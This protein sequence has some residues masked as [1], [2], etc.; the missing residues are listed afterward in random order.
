M[1][2]KPSKILLVLLSVA[3][4]QSAF[5]ATSANL[6]LRGTVGAANAISIASNGTN[7][8]TLDVL[9]GEINKNVASATEVSN[10]AAGYKIMLSSTNGGLLVNTTAPSQFTAYTVGYDGL[11]AVAPTTT[12]TQIKNVSS[13]SS[14]TTHNSSIVVNVTAF[15]VAL[16]GIYEDTVTLSI[17]AN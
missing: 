11:T 5:A 16:A 7:N 2:M 15:P 8:T 4:A 9:N 14:T 10:N 13:L 1:I 12:P 17:V 6:L 3:A